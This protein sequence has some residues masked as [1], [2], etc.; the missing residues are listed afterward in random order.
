MLTTLKRHPVPIDAHF[1]DCLVLTYAMRPE[2]L[3]PFLPAGLALDTHRGLG[4]LAIAMVQARALRPSGF[5]RFLGRDFFLAGF[6]IFTKLDVPGEP[7]RRGLRIL[8]SLTDR[9]AMRVFGNLLTH[10]NYGP[11]HVHRRRTDRG[12]EIAL[13][14]PNGN[15]DL[16]VSADLSGPALKP[17]DGSPF[18]DLSEARRFAGPLPL[19]F[20]YE[21]ATHSIVVIR[22]AREHWEPL[23]VRVEVSM[24]RFLQRACFRDAGA[25]L[26]NAFFVSDVS[27]HWGRGIRLPLARPST[28]AAV[29]PGGVP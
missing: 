28:S 20:D 23:A 8:Q 4:M 22:G 24:N 5:P 12:L 7:A 25:V 3:V 13:D 27:Y 18:A 9:P 1:E 16:R 21:A 29:G 11:C 17:P 15:A 6:R 10:Y 14:T 2:T 26:A 19:T